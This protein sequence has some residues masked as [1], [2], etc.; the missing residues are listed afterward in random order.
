MSL[1]KSLSLF[2]C[3]AHTLDAEAGIITCIESLILP[4][5]QKTFPY[6]VE[7]I[8]EA[9]IQKLDRKLHFL[10]SSSDSSVSQKTFISQS[11]SY[12][13]PLDKFLSENR[14]SKG[15]AR[16]MIEEL[17]GA[18]GQGAVFHAFDHQEQREVAIK[19]SEE[20]ENG[21]AAIMLSNKL[22]TKLRD[23][24]PL[25][26]IFD[27]KVKDGWAI[28]TSE[29]VPDKNY[30][31]YRKSKAPFKT[32]EG[33]LFFPYTTQTIIEHLTIMRNLARALKE[34]HKNEFL[35]TDLKSENIAVFG[36]L[37]VK[38]LDLDSL[39]PLEDHGG[40]SID[41]MPLITSG[42]ESPE[43]KALWDARDRSKKT[44]EALATK[45]GIKSDSYSL[46][47]VLHDMLNDFKKNNFKNDPL[48]NS[49]MD[50]LLKEVIYPLREATPEN[51][52]SMEEAEKKLDELIAS[53]KKSQK[54]S[55]SNP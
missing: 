9:V 43:M 48:V 22:E 41:T 42:H 33:T 51:R 30:S 53:I 8:P 19:I 7:N 16:F 34:I 50:N 36:D 20:H 18:G 13:I 38:L 44:K 3:F 28:T 1:R 17:L 29:W 39:A 32:P 11:D 6:K 21:P 52:I 5:R 24:N 55:S 31:H 35:Y 54:T 27:Y 25:L 10:T 12:I 37:Q 40:V 49:S 46:S 47:V 15:K 26:T 2:L 14:T 4:H 45:V 23:K